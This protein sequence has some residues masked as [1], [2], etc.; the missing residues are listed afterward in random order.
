[1]FYKGGSKRKFTNCTSEPTRRIGIT[2]SGG[3]EMLG[4]DFNV[5][6]LEGKTT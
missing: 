4:M 1:M 2:F 6:K 5:T 3:H